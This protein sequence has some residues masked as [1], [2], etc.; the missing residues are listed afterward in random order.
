MNADILVLDN[1]RKSIAYI[2]ALA[3][4]GY[5]I[6]EAHSPQEACDL[7]SVGDLPYAVIIDLKLADMNE[8]LPALR[9]EA[10][11]QVPMIVIGGDAQ[12]AYAAGADV[13][14]PKPVELDDL[15]QIVR[16]RVIA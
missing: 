12:D 8:V 3:G 10:G 13:V 11:S 6:A 4:F 2:A 7:L 14:L 16:S 9:R 5:R 15:L 1:N